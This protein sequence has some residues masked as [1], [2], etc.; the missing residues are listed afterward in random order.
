MTTMNYMM[1]K[2]VIYNAASTYNIY[3]YVCMGC[4]EIIH[5]DKKYIYCPM[6]GEKI[7]WSKS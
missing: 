3:L 4:N 7:E 1:K 5:M 2:S 6:C